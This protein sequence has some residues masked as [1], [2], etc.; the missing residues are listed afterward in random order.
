MAT[1]ARITFVLS[2]IAANVLAGQPEREMRTHYLIAGRDRT[3]LY[4]VTAITSASETL[5]SE[6]YLIESTAGQR[7]VI[8]IRRDYA[9]HLSTADY[10]V[11]GA[12]HVRVTIQ[13]PGKGA[14][15]SESSREY[16]E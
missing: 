6:T 4:S 13:L 10:A 16:R 1:L 11:N 7:I 12:K 3:P 2:F 15:R 14:T 8:A 9:S 5:G